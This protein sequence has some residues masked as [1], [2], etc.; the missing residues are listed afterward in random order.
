MTT[1]RMNVQMVELDRQWVKTK[2]DMAEWI[3]GRTGTSVEEVIDGFRADAAAEGLEWRATDPYDMKRR[4]V[5]KALET[6]MGG[7]ETAARRA[8]NPAET[9]VTAPATRRAARPASTAALRRVDSAVI[10]RARR[11]MGRLGR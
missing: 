9:A 10:E 1:Y 6:P 11:I 7:R 8:T 3:A 5:K 2:K 4:A